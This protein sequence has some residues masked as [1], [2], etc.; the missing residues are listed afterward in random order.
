[1]TE[2]ACEVVWRDFAGLTV[3]ELHDILK[4]RCDVFIVEQRILCEEIDGRDPETVHGLVRHDGAV[5]GTARIFPPGAD[6]AARVGRVATRRDLRGLGLGR[7]LMREAVAEI[8]RR[9]GTVPIVLG[10]QSH[11]VDFYV[12]FGFEAVSDIYDD[13]GIPHVEMRRPA[14]R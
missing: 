14:V 7:T 4:L 11:L 13:H 5:A 8:T 6:G 9:F 1:M 2:Q 10:A 3:G 12:G